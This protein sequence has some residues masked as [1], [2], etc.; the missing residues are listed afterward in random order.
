MTEQEFEKMTHVR[1]A[2]S[3]IEVARLAVNQ[4][5]HASTYK[6]KQR[7]SNVEKQ[8]DSYSKVIKLSVVKREGKDGLVSMEEEFDKATDFMNVVIAIASLVPTHPALQQNILTRFQKI[9]EDEL[10]ILNGK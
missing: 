7:L 1:T 5:K 6:E 8:M 10:E 2:F 4:I 9:V 3:C